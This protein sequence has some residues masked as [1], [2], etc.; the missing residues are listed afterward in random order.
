[1]N[2]IWISVTLL[3]SLI[4]LLT[5][6]VFLKNKKPTLNKHTVVHTTLYLMEA[7]IAT[8]ILIYLFGVSEEKLNFFEIFR[9]YVFCFTVYNGLLYFTFRM[10]DSLVL[11]SLTALRTRIEK[12]MI[13]AEFEKIIPDELLER[14]KKYISDDGISFRQKD[15]EELKQIIEACYLYNQGKFKPNDFRFVLKKKIATIDHDIKCYGFTWMNSIFL[16]TFK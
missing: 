9:N 15:K 6:T 8:T 5:I 7:V 10:H 16:R 1:M 3:I 13:H 12:Y 11:D 2:Y 4:G 14:D